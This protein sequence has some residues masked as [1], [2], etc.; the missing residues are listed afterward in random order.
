MFG[1]DVRAPEISS[2]ILLSVDPRIV[3]SES[4]DK[5]YPGVKA[6][7][8][9]EAR[10]PACA[11]GYGYLPEVAIEELICMGIG[12]GMGMGMGVCVAEVLDVGISTGVC[13]Y[14]G[15]GCDSSEP[16][17]PIGRRW[18]LWLRPGG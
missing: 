9:A 16:M 4:S 5:G 15:A 3:G 18:P 10:P 12:M 6:A 17:K 1:L 2:V 7:V 11:P 13:V 8:A 14:V